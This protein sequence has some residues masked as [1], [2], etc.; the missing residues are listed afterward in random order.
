MKNVFYFSMILM[1]FMMLCSCGNNKPGTG[2]P[3][4]TKELFGKLPD[5]RS[6]DIYTLVNNHG[7][8]ARI[9]N[10]GGIVTSLMTPDK[11]G[12]LAD[13][14]LGYDRLEDYLKDSPYFG[15][16]VGRY[17]NRIAGG[18]FSL[19]GVEYTLARNNGPNHLHG[20][21]R[22]FD[23]VLWDAESFQNETGVGL[24]LTYLSKD[25]EEGYPGN[26]RVTVIYNLTNKNELSISYE[27]ETDKATPVNITHH[28]YFNLAG[29]GNGDILGQELTINAGRYTVVDNTLIPTGE[30]RD[31]KNTPMDFLSPHKIGER[32]GQVDGGY[33]HNYVLDNWDGTLHMAAI[34]D[35]PVSGRM[36]EVLTTEPGVQF[37]SGNFLNGSNIG[38]GG[39]AYQK[40]AGFCL[41]TQ[42]FPDSP[43]HP[44]F[45]S[46]ILLPGK[47]YHHFTVYRFSAK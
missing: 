39:K 33:D 26:L 1:S 5:G 4:V 18:K 24:K 15:A 45:P 34:V 2:K 35:E 13:V 32:I 37:Y 6:A 9:T 16:I 21:I 19:D 17:G 8:I 20:G 47:K 42:H 25:G 29:A 3:G 40:H 12:K 10:Y 30:L 43:N 31:V 23:K 7:M 36:M 22:G 41:E 14:V 27:A 11:N 38:K 44:D 46:V 28:G